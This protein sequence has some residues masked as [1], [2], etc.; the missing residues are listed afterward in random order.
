MTRRH[1]TQLSGVVVVTMNIYFIYKMTVILPSSFKPDL[2]K[3]NISMI[4]QFLEQ[5]L[6][7]FKT[8]FETLA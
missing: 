8:C 2:V 7:K 4:N 1:T 5:M 6:G 3:E